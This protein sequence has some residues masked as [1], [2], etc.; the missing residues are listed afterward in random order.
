MDNIKLCK[1]LKNRDIIE[2][3]LGDK[4]IGV[5]NNE[6]I[7]MPYVTYR[8]ID[9]IIRSLRDSENMA[10]TSRSTAMA[11]VLR[12]A[13][14]INKAD[15]IFN[16]FLSKEHFVSLHKISDIE[17]IKNRYDFIIKS[18]INKINT[19]MYFYDFKLA[20]ADSGFKVISI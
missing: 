15:E 6:N 20:K 19:I 9:T 17:E 5:Y 12:R 8:E 4:I 3:L 7:Y 18:V 14:N 1:C 2:I 10:Y 13:I 11:D 16:Y